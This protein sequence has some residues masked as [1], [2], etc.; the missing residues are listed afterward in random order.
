MHTLMIS[1]AGYI[2]TAA[3]LKIID[4][5]L[6]ALPFLSFNYD[7]LQMATLTE[8][9][10]FTDARVKGTEGRCLRSVQPHSRSWAR[11]PGDVVERIAT[12]LKQSDV[13]D[14]RRMRCVNRHW[15][16]Y[17]SK[18]ITHLNLMNTEVNEFSHF[19]ETCTNVFVNAERLD[20]PV[21]WIDDACCEQLAIALPKLSA[22]ELFW[23]DS[24]TDTGLKA[25]A[26]LPLESFKIYHSRL[27]TDEGI[28]LLS[29][30]PLEELWIYGA[31]QVTDD[32]FRHL[33]RLDS[34]KTLRLMYCNRLSRRGL[35]PLFKREGL[36]I[37]VRYCRRISTEICIA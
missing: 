30:C 25:L 6:R 24:V 27:I 15:S 37:F 10:S 19:L 8:S 11:L 7:S 12:I 23:G 5:L 14:L 9:S 17:A 28:A 4:R 32:G 31:N 13:E 33:E 18:A 36:Q 3:F 1:S 26:S 22:L 16:E 35:E 29:R 20:V 34:I 21:V 2:R